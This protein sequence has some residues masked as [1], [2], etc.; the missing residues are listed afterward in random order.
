MSYQRFALQLKVDDS[1]LD[2]PERSTLGAP[3]DLA[4]WTAA[5]L[6]AAIEGGLVDLAAS[7][8][9]YEGPL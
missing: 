3:V 2:S 9:R 7:E 5:D 4:E 1:V 6:V 8:L